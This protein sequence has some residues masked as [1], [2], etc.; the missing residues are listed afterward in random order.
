MS[1][2]LYNPDKVRA[3]G[4]DELTEVI[5]RGTMSFVDVGLCLGEIRRRES[6]GKPQHGAHESFEAYVRDRWGMSKSYASR[7]IS[8][9]EICCQLATQFD[10]LPR[11]ESVAR[12]LAALEDPVIWL[13]ED[14]KLDSP[15]VWQ[16]AL[17]MSGR[18]E[19]TAAV[20]TKAIAEF[21]EDARERISRA[22]AAG[23]GTATDTA[24]ET[25]TET[26]TGTEDE[27]EAA[28]EQETTEEAID[29]A[30]KLAMEVGFLAD[31]AMALH[32][33]PG[34]WEEFAGIKDSAD[35][36]AEAL[37]D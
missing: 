15:M 33:A 27:Q 6:W 8:A 7:M 22:R 16:Q 11:N 13:D 23:G 31:D 9:A 20:V 21:R 24:T 3:L 30:A 28:E 12:A 18:T 19:P 1:E 32:L 36:M 26:E 10:R 25:E 4:P 37:A 34:V 29:P 2:L 35:D 17:D 5:D 14:T